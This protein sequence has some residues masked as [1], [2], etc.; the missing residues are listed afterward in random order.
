MRAELSKS[1]ATRHPYP[2]AEG[3]SVQSHE[4]RGRGKGASHHLLEHS[5]AV[6]GRLA[7]WPAGGVAWAAG[8]GIDHL[9]D[10]G[11]LLGRGPYRRGLEAGARWSTNHQARCG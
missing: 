3:G 10:S 2:N 8:G 5:G 1:S 6:A 9:A 4:E 7:S 11:W